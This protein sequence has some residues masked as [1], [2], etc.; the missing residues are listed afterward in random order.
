MSIPV[1]NNIDLNGNQLLNFR[2]Q[3][4]ASDPGSP[5]AGQIWFNT[6]QERLKYFDGTTVHTLA[7]AGG[8]SLT[9]ILGSTPV[10]ATDNGDGTYTISINAAT[11]SAAGSMSSS[12]K[13]KLDGIDEGAEVNPT[14]SDILTALLTVDGSGSGLDADTVDGKHAS[15]FVETT[16]LGANNGVATLDSGGKLASAQIPDALLGGLAFQGAWNAST[17]TPTLA[18]GTGTH[19][20]YYLVDTAGTTTLDGISDWKVGDWVVFVDEAWVKIDNTDQVV[21][22]NGQQGAVVLDADDIAYDGTTSG[23]VAETLQDA[24]DEVV[25]DLAAAAAQRYSTSVGDG[26]ATQ[27][28]VTHG[29]GTRDVVVSVRE[30]AS[31]YAIVLCDVEALSTSQVRLRFAVAPTSNQY[32]VTVLA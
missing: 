11:T 12:D 24:V 21:S 6:T 29:L 30:V 31:P 22:V 7:T 14:A 20:H 13:T 3:Q 1:L 5:T 8:G 18:S 19:G 32:R 23:L 2:A 10:V 26:N 28:D 16:A 9:G 17:N 4:L 27:I 15:A 25:S